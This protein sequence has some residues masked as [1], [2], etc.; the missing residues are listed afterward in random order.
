MQRS[1]EF[2]SYLSR[3]RIPN[4]DGLRGLA[5]I[6][7]LQNTQEVETRLLFITFAMPRAVL[8]LVTLLIRS[9]LGLLLAWRLKGKTA[10]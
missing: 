9:I 6:L 10:S 3:Q 7:V 4:L 1:E 2:A 5:I 8:L